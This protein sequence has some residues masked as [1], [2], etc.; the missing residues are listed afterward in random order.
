MENR[1]VPEVDIM[2]YA[3]KWYSILSIPRFFNKHWRQTIET[4]VIHP[5]GYYAVFTTYKIVNEQEIKY[6]RSKLTAVRGTKNSQFK[7]QVVWPFK[8]DYWVIELAEDCSY[9]VVGH[10]N[11]KSLTIMSRKPEL[12]ENL[13]SD[14]IDRCRRKG[15]D[16]SLLVSQGHQVIH[17]PV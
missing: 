9:A 5:D 6:F 7:L 13:L 15:Y 17:Q 1:P 16:T 14:I 4:Y 10:P 12:P 8:D 2:M 3:G 11:L